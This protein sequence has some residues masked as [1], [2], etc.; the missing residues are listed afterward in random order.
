MTLTLCDIIRE[1]FKKTKDIKLSTFFCIL[2]SIA[3]ITAGMILAY[4]T[5]GPALALIIFSLFYILNLPFGAAYHMIGLK[6]ARD[7][8]ITHGIAFQY[9]EKI[10]PIFLIALLGFLLYFCVGF[11][12]QIIANAFFEGLFPMLINDSANTTASMTSFIPHYIVFIITFALFLS[13][14]WLN[15]LCGYAFVFALMGTLD[16]NLNP[17]EAYTQSFHMIHEQYVMLLLLGLTLTVCLIIG[18]VTIIGLIWVIPMI[19]VSGGIL[20]QAWADKKPDS[21]KHHLEIRE[22]KG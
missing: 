8:K 2:C 9:F 14:I 15:I 17:I 5:Q 1:A 11:A 20:Y 19:A 3:T 4:L 7:E 13:Q 6:T 21:A 12:Y 22:R 16:K 10:I 18:A